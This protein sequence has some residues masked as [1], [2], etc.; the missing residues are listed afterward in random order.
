MTYFLAK[1]NLKR[2][3]V[4]LSDS[5]LGQVKRGLKKA[6]PL[7][8][9]RLG[10]LA[11]I[12]LLT[13]APKATRAHALDFDERLG[14]LQDLPCA[15]DQYK[16]YES[17]SAIGAEATNLIAGFQPGDEAFACRL[18]TLAEEHERLVARYPEALG[19]QEVVAVSLQWFIELAR[20]GHGGCVR[21]S[22]LMEL[23]AIGLEASRRRRNSL[24]HIQCVIVVGICFAC[25][26]RDAA[27]SAVAVLTGMLM[28]AFGVEPGQEGVCQLMAYLGCVDEARR[29]AMLRPYREVLL[30]MEALGNP[31]LSRTLLLLQPYERVLASFKRVYAVDLLQELARLGLL[32]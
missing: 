30:E 25:D 21:A 19:N 18:K 17:A 22:G 29:K 16:A 8:S 31:V 2:G 23:A 24:F 6:D 12:R 32:E 13:N 10:A 28:E 20:L 26:K 11:D 1:F 14:A 27:F 4:K 15:D 9:R 3:K 5:H 7:C